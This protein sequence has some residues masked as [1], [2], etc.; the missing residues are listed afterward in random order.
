MMLSDK[1]IK[2]KLT[3]ILN[4]SQIREVDR[5]TIAEKDITSLE[6][7]EYAATQA[8]EFIISTAPASS[9]VVWVG[10]GNNG[11]DGLA[12]ARLLAQEGYQV[13]VWQVAHTNNLTPDCQAN[14]QALP[15]NVCY[16]LLQSPDDFAL[17]PAYQN[18]TMIDALL[19]A[20]LTRPIEKDSLLALAIS[21][22]NDFSHTNHI[23]SIDIASGLSADMDFVPS[24]AIKPHQTVSFELPKLAFLFP[25]N[26][27]YS[28]HWQTTPIGLSKKSIDEMPT[29]Y[30]YFDSVAAK[31]FN[32]PRPK[33]SHK[34]SFGHVLIWGGS[35][36]KIG[37]V[38]LAAKAALHSGAG[39]VTVY[40]PRCGYTPVQAAIPEAMC[41]TD[42]HEYYLTQI[43]DLTKYDTVV[44]G[45]GM[46]TQTVSVEALKS[47]LQASTTHLVLDADALNLIAQQALQHYI[48]HNTILTP[49]LK[50]F[51]RLFG[52]T[53]DDKTRLNLLIRQATNLQLRI[54]LKGAHTAVAYPDGRVLFNSS[55][56][57]AMAT[58]GS[59][60]VLAGIIGAKISDLR[61][62]SIPET[63][64][65]SVFLHGIA[66]EMA[67]ES[68]CDAF[69]TASNII[70]HLANEYNY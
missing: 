67:A 4:T 50:E 5:Q 32:V 22:I 15:K 33:F 27:A 47:L 23:I 7:M 61:Y 17:I 28:Q 70:E 35:Y 68:S 1:N 37:A 55:G 6:L 51:E 18:K 42:T 2:L 30:Y 13:D 20:G 9:F 65:Y 16:H 11:G 43:P 44:A 10:M 57:P 41:L 12:M 49:H 66:G 3:K 34:G 52:K 56:S 21:K 64:S 31:Y 53:S 36:G 63:V 14:R 24:V 39:L 46:D 45:V 19:G 25:Q 26:Q 38:I 59:G 40:V 69:V 29:P 54:V 48:P 58:A 60:D 8:K 62:A